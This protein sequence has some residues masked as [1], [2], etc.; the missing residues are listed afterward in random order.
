MKPGQLGTRSADRRQSLG[1][2]L[3]QTQDTHTRE[4]QTAFL[5]AEVVFPHF[6]P[7]GKGG[8]LLKWGVA[9]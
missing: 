4:Q 1:Q 5:G 3:L 6:G 7:M 8:G 2:Q 9:I